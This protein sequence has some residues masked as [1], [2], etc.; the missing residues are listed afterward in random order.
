M[1]ND[2]RMTASN[3]NVDRLTTDD[4]FGDMF[5]YGYAS[6]EDELQEYLNEPT[7]NPT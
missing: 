3:S 5:N 4:V 2:P 1:C 7:E 6:N